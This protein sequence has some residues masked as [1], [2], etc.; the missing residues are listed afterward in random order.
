MLRADGAP[1]A[2]SVYAM[3]S[4]KAVGVGSLSYAGYYSAYYQ[5]T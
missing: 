2:G 1:L 5:T 4:P 3:V